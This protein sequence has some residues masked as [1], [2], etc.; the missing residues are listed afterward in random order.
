MARTDRIGQDIKKK[1]E[2]KLLNVDYFKEEILVVDA[3]KEDYDNAVAAIDS[4]LL[5]QIEAVNSTVVG[6][7]SIYQERIDAGCKSDLFWRVEG[8]S[9]TDYSLI[10][11]KL[12]PVGYGTTVLLVDPLGGITTIADGEVDIPGAMEG[13]NLH[14]I[15]YYNEPYLKDIGDTTIGTFI[16]IV[17]SASTILSVVSQVSSQI[18]SIFNVDNLI[19]ASKEGV[20]SNERNRIVGFGTTT[21]T[22]ISTSVMDEVVGIATTSLT[23]STIILESPTIGFSSL[24]ESDG[25]YVNFTVVTD[26][27]TF[28][29]LAPRFKYQVKFTKHPFSPQEIGIMDSSMVGMGTFIEYTNSGQPP[30]TQTWK[31][32]FDG[33]KIDGEKVKEPKVGAGKVYNVIGFDS[34]PSIFGNP[35]PE[36]T[37]FTTTTLVGLYSPISASGCNSFDNQIAAAEAEK[38]AAESGLAGNLAASIDAANSLRKER[39]EYALKIWGLR[40]SIGGESDRVDELEVLES[41]VSQNESVINE[42]E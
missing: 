26:P 6:L 24:P 28:E 25:T 19:I 38:A 40:Q 12:S 30:N 1:K 21:I 36:G 11:T 20:F 14:A 17:G 15:K 41:F 31:P 22:G 2:Q 18:I 32:E 27:D 37:T 5:G 33:Q 42:G 3:E 34:E 39:G 4:Q 9:G 16:G 35:Q 7:S 13:Q 10:V 23:V 29:D 8:V